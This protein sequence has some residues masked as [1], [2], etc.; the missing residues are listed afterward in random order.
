M[1]LHDAIRGKRSLSLSFKIVGETHLT[2]AELNQLEK[3]MLFNQSAKKMPMN[4]RGGG[5]RA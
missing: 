2:S 5:D 3:E 4:L 1:K